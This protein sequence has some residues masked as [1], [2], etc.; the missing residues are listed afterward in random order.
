M[1]GTLISRHC[2][3]CLQV[4]GNP[5]IQSSY[6][7]RIVSKRLCE[8]IHLTFSDAGLALVSISEQRRR[9]HAHRRSNNVF[10]ILVKP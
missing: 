5:K 8:V 7:P 1:L 6:L 3:G 4:H 10:E 9:L 2:I